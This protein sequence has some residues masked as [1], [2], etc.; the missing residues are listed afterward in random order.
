MNIKLIHIHSVLIR[1]KVAYKVD[2]Y[3]VDE[4]TVYEYTVYEYTVDEYTVDGHL[5]QQ[6][7]NSL[8]E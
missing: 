1:Y 5:S 3:R 6:Q 7:I 8:L 2:K 4:Y